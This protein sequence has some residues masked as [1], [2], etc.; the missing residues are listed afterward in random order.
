METETFL[1]VLESESPSGTMVQHR[2]TVEAVSSKHALIKLA[3][4]IAE[5]EMTS[6]R[7]DRLPTDS[8]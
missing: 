8:L 3:N 2:W 4:K 1:V 7:I 5:Y 6:L